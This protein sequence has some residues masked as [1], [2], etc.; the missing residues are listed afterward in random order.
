MKKH[1]VAI[2]DDDAAFGAYLKT[3]LS[4]RGYDARTYARGDE[5]VAAMRGADAP[6]IVLLDVTMPGKDGVETLKNVRASAP[7][8]PVVML[9]GNSETA[10]VVKA[11][12]AGAT[13]F[14][15]K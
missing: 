11:M 4:L 9:S 5:F 13:D 2:V 6:D 8:L 14:I 7:D 12:Q 1:L 3:F 15:E 10:T